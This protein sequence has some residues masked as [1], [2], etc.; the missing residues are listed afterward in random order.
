L[1]NNNYF[2]LYK[3]YLDVLYKKG[4]NLLINIDKLINISIS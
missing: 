3:K 2:T 4:V 1:Y